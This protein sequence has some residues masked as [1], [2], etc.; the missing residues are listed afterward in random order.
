MVRELAKGRI[1]A[2][3]GRPLLVALLFSIVPPAAHGSERL[4]A[5]YELSETD[6]TVTSPDNCIITR[7]LQGGGVPSATEGSYV[8]KLDCTGEWDRKVEVKHE[9][10]GSTF[11]L[12]GYGGLLVDVYVETPSALPQ[13]MGAWLFSWLEGFGL[14][15]ATGQWTEVSM[16]VY[17]KDDVDLEQIPALKFEELGADDVVIYLDNLRLVPPRQVRFADHDWTVKCGG[18]LGP[19]LN[20]FSQSGDHVWVDG[21]GHLRLKIAEYRTLWWCSEL[22]LNESFGYGTYVFT[23]Q[24]RVDFDE[25]IILGLFTWD[26][27]ASGHNYRE[28][29]FEFGRWGDPNDDNAQFVVQP[30]NTQGNRLRF[31]IGYDG[32]T[33]TTTH[34]MKWRSDR[35]EFTSYYGDFRIIPPPENIIKT[36]VYSGG[37]NPPPG[38]ENVRINFWLA[39]VDDP[40]DQAGNPP[41]NGQEAEVVITHFRYL[42]EFNDIPAVRSLGVALGIVMLLGAAVF[43]LRRSAPSK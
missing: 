22:I 39:D 34:V 21:N 14:P 6:L 10:S 15:T 2:M 17:D 38:E 26:P 40:P 5:G 12:A 20:A 28:I 3:Y 30:W 7:P 13:I 19:G 27:D 41:V 33:E 42:S 25:N 8:L 11:D 31:D 18:W 37:D 1:P 24:S 36:W 9:W 23:V 29:D 4:L 35:I 32:P 43:V 16:C